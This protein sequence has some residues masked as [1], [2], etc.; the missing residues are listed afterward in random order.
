MSGSGNQR[1]AETWLKLELSTYEVCDNSKGDKVVLQTGKKINF[2]KESDKGYESVIA[3]TTR[4]LEE[5]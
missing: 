2:P 5:L 1:A 4:N 3:V